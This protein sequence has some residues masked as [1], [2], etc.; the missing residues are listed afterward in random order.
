[1]QT[2]AGH[3]ITDSITLSSVAVGNMV[4]KNLNNSWESSEHNK[5]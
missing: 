5:A 3:H 1:M 2:Q 4:F